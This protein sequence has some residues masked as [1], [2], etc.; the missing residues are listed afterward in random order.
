[1]HSSL[2]L[3]TNRKILSTINY[4]GKGSTIINYAFGRHLKSLKSRR[5][6]C[7]FLKVTLAALTSTCFN[8]SKR[9]RTF[10]G[11]FMCHCFQS[12]LLSFKRISSGWQLSANRKR[13]WF[14]ESANPGTPPF[15]ATPSIELKERILVV[16]ISRHNPFGKFIVSFYNLT[17]LFFFNYRIG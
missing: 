2:T 14:S 12:H 10:R 17:L 16:S 7:I 8:V 9:V 4:L 13:H 3:H 11:N 15:V 6:V 1:M 5:D